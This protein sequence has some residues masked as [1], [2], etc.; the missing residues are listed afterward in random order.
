M[1]GRLFKPTSGRRPDLPDNEMM[2]VLNDNLC[3]PYRTR[4]LIP[5][6]TPP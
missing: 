4:M 5:T 3:R 2:D 6:R 1:V